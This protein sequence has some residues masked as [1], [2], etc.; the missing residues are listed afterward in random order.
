MVKITVKAKWQK[1]RGMALLLALFALLLLS[2]IG[3]GMVLA[4]YTETRVDTNYNGS[5]RSYYAA[6]SGLEEVR[7]RISFPFT[8]ASPKGLA[9]QLPQDIAGNANGVL[10]VLNPAG[11]EIVDPTDPTSPYFDDQ[12]CHD[13][14]SGVAATDSRC[15]V[16]PGTPNWN[17]P[18][19]HSVPTAIPMGY[20]WVRVNMKTNRIAAPYYVDGTGTSAALDT[21]VCWDGKTEQL[22]PSATNP[23]CDANGMQQ[24][25]M[26]TS[27]AASAQAG[28]PNGS[29]SLLRF[30]VVAPA[31]RPPGAVTMEVG[32]S[33]SANPIPATFNNV[34]IPAT[35]IDGRVHG[36]DLSL[37]AAPTCSSVAALAANSPQGAASL[38]LGL[39][40]LRRSIVQAANSSC[41]ADGTSIAPNT[42]TPALAWVRG[43]GTN[44]QFTTTSSTS[45][46]STTS[47][48]PT[49]TPTPSPTPTTSQTSNSGHDG[50]GGDHSPTPTPTPT[51]IP[52]P[53]PTPTP[54]S[55]SDCS[56][57]TQSCYTSL[58]L[59]ATQIS[60]SPLFVGNPGNSGDPAV[61]QAQNT[62][63]VVNE[64]QAVLDYIAA[65]KA[66][67]TNYFEV[68]STSLATTYGSLTQPAVVVIT[69]SSLK[70][71][72]PGVSLTG[73]GILEVPN[74]FEIQNAVLQW[75]GI[76]LVRSTSGQF[77]I[78]TGA[79][80]FINGALM[81]QSG[82]QFTLTTS[83]A[84]ANPFKIA[85]S[86]DA[87]DFAMGSRPVKVVA[88]TESSH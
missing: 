76:V 56:T 24:V 44:P 60:P 8:T 15:T 5:L 26:L 10:Y 65:S 57:A 3:L 63:I 4:S 18:W 85:Y 20:K 49:P 71:L 88:Q 45:A 43:T 87:I 7:D 17:M 32:S 72:G 14:A 77:L 23:A 40:N 61:Y 48:T 58:D 19:Q 12:L 46:I 86:C 39:N 70:L 75:T 62:N 29:R 27:L 69:D 22:T 34:L 80:G 84:G 74:D 78:N 30:E 73:Y 81:L 2:A 47:P 59:S 41:N 37:S 33:T 50:H 54:V 28:G 53:T 64:N 55:T 68:A 11:G 83:S 36:L 42:C 38:Q 9:D 82:N 25:Y 51:P 31:I 67:G 13:Y 35:S 1:E 79:A 21:R 16:V 6:R 66:S 52:T